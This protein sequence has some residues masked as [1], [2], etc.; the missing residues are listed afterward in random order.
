[1]YDPPVE[2][3]PTPEC[4]CYSHVR[5]TLGIVAVIS[6]LFDCIGYCRTNR[7][8]GELQAEN[9]TLK[10]IVRRSVDKTITQILKN[11]YQIDSE[12]EE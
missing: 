9:T 6:L 10:D 11:G 2:V 7:K 4:N 3:T 12:H 5:V 1:M 8:L